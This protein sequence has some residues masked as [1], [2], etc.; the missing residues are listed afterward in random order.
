MLCTH[1]H[2]LR[3]QPS[4]Y[5]TAGAAAAAAPL[6]AL[7]ALVLRVG[8]RQVLARYQV[9]HGGLA[10]GQLQRAQGHIAMQESPLVDQAQNLRLGHGLLGP[11]LGPVVKHVLGDLGRRVIGAEGKLLGLAADQDQPQVHLVRGNPTAH[12]CRNRA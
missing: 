8:L 11:L 1:T 7:L 3:R 12:R 6:F 4:Q 2:T 10:Q 5:A 9:H